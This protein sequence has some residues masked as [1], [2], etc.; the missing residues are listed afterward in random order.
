MADSSF[1]GVPQFGQND[2]FGTSEVSDSTGTDFICPV[3]DEN[4]PLSS[5]RAFKS[6]TIAR[7]SLIVIPVF[8]D[9]SSILAL[10]LSKK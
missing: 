4:F 5:P 3:L 6:N 10:E 9:I 8:A 1:T 7:T 2:A